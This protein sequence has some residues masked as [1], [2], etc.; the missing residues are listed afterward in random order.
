MSARNQHIAVVGAGLVGLSSALWLQRKGFRVSVVDPEPPGS[1]TSSGNACTIAT[2]G[3]IPV[4]SP[5]LF[6]QLP[7]LALS[8][9]SPLTVNPLYALTHPRWMLGFLA[10]C[11]AGRVNHIIDSL[12]GLLAHTWDGLGP[13]LD[14]AGARDLVEERGFMHLYRDQHEFD[15]AWPANR[16]RRDHGTRFTTLDAGEILDL[17]PNL[18]SG[19]TRGLLF[20]GIHQVLEPR[21]LCQRYADC[22]AERGGNLVRSRV[23]ALRETGKG[24][25]LALDDGAA[26]SADRVVIAAGAF[27]RFIAGLDGTARRLDTERGYH[28]L[29]RDRQ[30]LLSR[31]VSWHFAG[32][33]ATPMN[34]GLRFAGTVEIAGYRPRENPRMTRYLARRAS[35]MFDLPPT[36]DDTWLGFRPTFPDS[37]PAIGH[38]RGSTRVLYATGHHHLGLTLSGITGRLIAELVAGEQPLHD[39]SAFDPARFAS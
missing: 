34:L 16:I 2:Y 7:S 5:A 15:A 20:E 29:Y 3:C 35:Q 24:V 22:L 36:P 1:G 33:Y 13:L 38:A 18:K 23:K 21:A 30:D 8:R 32:F 11:R 31:P 12:A 26:L 39:P 14:M 17:E 25:E 28:V 19:F 6:R 37:L 10:N 9:E 27:A 4:N